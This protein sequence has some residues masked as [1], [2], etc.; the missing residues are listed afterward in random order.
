MNKII[1]I[2][3][4]NSPLALRQANIVK[5]ILK[6]SVKCELTPM[7]SSGDS[8]STK[9]FKKLGGKG[10]FLKELEESLLSGDTDIAV[11]SLKDVPYILN[12]KFEITTISTREVSTD[13]FISNKYRSIL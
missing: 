4:R 2:A 11:H 5:D 12:N 10:L 8:A 6:E 7:T 1:R 9:E 3:T 13:A